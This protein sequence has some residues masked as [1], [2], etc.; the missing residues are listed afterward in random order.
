[1]I[2]LLSSVIPLSIGAA[3]SPTVLA[4]TLVILGGK[5]KPRLKALIMIAGMSI[6]L[7]GLA[8]AAGSL[9]DVTANTEVK[10]VTLWLDIGLGIFL[11]GLGLRSILIKQTDVPPKP[12]LKSGAR[13][14]RSVAAFVP[15]GIVIMLTDFSSIVL[16]VPAIRDITA[17]SISWTAKLLVAAIPFI[18]VLIPA[19]VPLLA[20]T[21]SPDKAGQALQKLNVW[22]ARH[23]R[24]I[25]VSLAFAFGVFL[26]WKGASK[27]F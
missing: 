26:L 21:F 9:T 14:G 17:A 7:T 27:I 2:E 4:F 3:F 8:L 16:F 13:G 6:A 22:L 19:S 10:S 15:I 11:I 5:T 18:A 12:R 24:T 23:N 20:V 25:S 1:M